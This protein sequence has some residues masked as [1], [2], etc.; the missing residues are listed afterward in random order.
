MQLFDDNSNMEASGTIIPDEHTQRL[1]V[2]LDTPRKAAASPSRQKKLTEAELDAVRER[3]DEI[4]FI[5]EDFTNQELLMEERSYPCS[6]GKLLEHM[7]MFYRGEKPDVQH[8]FHI[9]ALLRPFLPGS[10]VK[11]AHHYDPLVAKHLAEEKDMLSQY[12]NYCLDALNLTEDD[13]A[14]MLATPLAHIVRFGIKPFQMEM[15]WY[16]YQSQLHSGQIF[17]TYAVVQKMG[18]ESFGTFKEEALAA[19]AKSRT[20]YIC[21]ACERP[22]RRADKICEKCGKGP[23]PCP[24][25]WMKYSPYTATKR[26][27]KL[28]DQMQNVVPERSLPS[29]VS[30]DNYDPDKIV[31]APDYPILWQS[32]TS[33]GHGSHAAC[34]ADRM[35]DPEVG[36][37]CPQPGCGCPCLPGPYR[38][39]YIRNEEEERVRREVGTVRTDERKARES[40]AVKSARGLLDEGKRVRVVEPEK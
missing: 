5:L 33:C 4:P 2:P 17:N 31:A 3:F 19:S 6:V 14:A 34:M 35:N 10:V 24:I 7:Y 26:T 9:V 20:A 12:A 27:K 39:R 15:A 38:D 1:D 13:V 8:I 23:A 21:L 32:C 11:R 28:F 40:G 18:G 37:C 36:G 30:D 25:C 16:T 22:I 29:S